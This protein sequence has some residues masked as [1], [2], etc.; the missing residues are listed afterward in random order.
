MSGTPGFT[1]GTLVLTAT[2]Q[3]ILLHLLAWVARVACSPKSYETV[4]IREITL[5]RLPP[6]GHCIDNR[7]K[8]IL[9]LL[10]KEAYLLVLELQP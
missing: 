6:S 5:G 1:S 3:G 9:S 4:T 8:L 2:A 10:V 7:L